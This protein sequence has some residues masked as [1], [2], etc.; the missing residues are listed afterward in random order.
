[1]RT[2]KIGDREIELKASPLALFY[3][4]QE[5]DTRMIEDTIELAS[6]KEKENPFETLDITKLLQLGW[7][8]NKAA[9]YNIDEVFPGFEKWLSRFDS[10]NIFG[11]RWYVD[12]AEEASDGF[13][14]SSPEKEGEEEKE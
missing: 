6:K 10:M 3:Y 7:A 13:F 9:R 8:M 2:T 12:V 14:R 1:M 5:F 11:G 4:S